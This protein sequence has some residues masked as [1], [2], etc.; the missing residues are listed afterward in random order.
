MDMEKAE[1]V[2]SQSKVFKSRYREVEPLS[3][4]ISRAN[5]NDSRHLLVESP[6]DHSPL[7][8]GEILLESGSQD[9]SQ[10]RARIEN[11]FQN[12]VVESEGVDS[13]AFYEAESRL[14]ARG[15]I[16]SSIS[17]SRGGR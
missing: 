4:D 1:L 11:N 16:Q 13:V 14:S 12:K 15:S 3:I 6:I 9:P 17:D 5:P 7:E 10:L 2:E 8:A